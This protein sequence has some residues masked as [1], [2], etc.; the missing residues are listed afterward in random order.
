MSNG[1]VMSE[2]V[3]SMTELDKHNDIVPAFVGS[4]LRW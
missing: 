3:H 2:V 4:E 1:H